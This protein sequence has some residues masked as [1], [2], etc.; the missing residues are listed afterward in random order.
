MNLEW[1]DI[2]VFGLEGGR[3][4]LLGLQMEAGGW[5]FKK[6]SDE[7]AAVDMLENENLTELAVQESKH[8]TTDLKEALGIVSP[9]WTNLYPLYIHKDFKQV[10]WREFIEP[11][12][13]KVKRLHKWERLC[14]MEDF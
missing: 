14:S 8:H 4:K 1:E 11:S 6:A 7:W 9:I 5:V 10:I 3:L 12:G 2:V 13:K